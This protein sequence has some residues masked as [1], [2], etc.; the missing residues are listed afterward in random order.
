VGP[1]LDLGG[2]CPL[3]P[4]A[5][6]NPLAPVSFPGNFPDEWFYYLARAQLTTPNGGLG[7][8]I[9]AVEGAFVNGAVVPGDQM[10]FSRLRIRVSGLVTNNTYAI[11]HPYG[12]D[13]LM[14]DGLGVINTTFDSLGGFTGP[15][16]PAGRVGPRYIV[17]DAALPAPPPGFVGGGPGVEHT[18]TGS[19]CGT[20]FFRVAGPGLPNGSVETNFFSVSGRIQDVCGNGILD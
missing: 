5:L 18:V 8:L 2:A 15:L 3:T 14:A 11:T 6:P 1:C 19:P 17:W 9:M 20:N 7:R 12:V 16:A 4:D 10:V 13:T